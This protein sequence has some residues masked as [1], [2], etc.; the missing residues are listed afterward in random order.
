ME[1][2][3]CTLSFA[4]AVLAAW[5]QVRGCL[6]TTREAG[7]GMVVELSRRYQKMKAWVRDNVIRGA[8]RM[9]VVVVGPRQAGSGMH[10]GVAGPCLW[11]CKVAP[12]NSP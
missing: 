10:G 2:L 1:S 3:S 8:L 6:P 9:L 4:Y 5:S 12:T 11:L 7:G